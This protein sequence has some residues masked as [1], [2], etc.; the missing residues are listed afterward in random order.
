MNWEKRAVDFV[1]TYQKRRGLDADGKAGNGTLEDI[2]KLLPPEDTDDMPNVGE[3]SLDDTVTWEVSDVKQFLLKGHIGND[4]KLDTLAQSG[5]LT[6]CA[7]NIGN[8]DPH[9]LTERIHRYGGYNDRSQIADWD[10][11]ERALEVLTGDAV[12][13]WEYTRH[14]DTP[15]ED[16]RDAL[17]YAPVIIEVETNRKSQ[18]FVVGY[19]VVDGEILIADPGTGSHHKG[20]GT[21]FGRPKNNDNTKTYSYVGYRTLRKV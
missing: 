10:A 17:Q 18:H 19:G 12:G 14:D 15:L 5:C 11:V 21:L 7:A 8:V 9:T 16:C 20:A 6:V 3:A 13:E 1:K 4:E 2:D